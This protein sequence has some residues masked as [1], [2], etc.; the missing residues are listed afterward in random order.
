MSTF[1]NA[2]EQRNKEKEQ[3]EVQL[4]I[5]LVAA[6][7]RVEEAELALKT[8]NDNFPALKKEWISEGIKSCADKVVEEL[9]K[10]FQ[11]GHDFT[12]NKLN[13][14]ANHEF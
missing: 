10:E 8:Y 6:V 1:Q 9:A 13:L 11:A 12:L 7:R 14:P 4:A 3:V 5:V 2:L